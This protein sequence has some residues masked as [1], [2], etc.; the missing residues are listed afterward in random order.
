MI[1]FLKSKNSTGPT[2][3]LQRGCGVFC[4]RLYAFYSAENPQW[5]QAELSRA[6]LRCRMRTAETAMS[7]AASK[8]TTTINQR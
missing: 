5:V 7:A 2:R 3:G 6:K 8:P 1:A 4:R